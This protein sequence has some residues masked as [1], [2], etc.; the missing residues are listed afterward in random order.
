MAALVLIID[1]HTEDR[2]IADVIEHGHRVLAR[3]DTA[4]EFI[5]ATD[6][7]GADT[8]L[9]S[10]AHETLTRALIEEADGRG[11]RLLVLAANSYERRHAAELGLYDVLDAG[12]RWEEIEE[13]LSVLT[14]PAMFTASQP[15]SAVPGVIAVWGSAGA[16]GRTALA[17]T[18]AAEL[19][20]A[21][22]RVVLVDADSYGGTVAPML[23]MLDEAPGFAAACRLAAADAL[24]L[25]ELDRVCQH[26][27][28]PGGEF[29][30]LTG[31]A[32]AARWPELGGTRV[33]AV[34]RA[35]RSWVDTVVI[36][37]GSSLENDEEISSDLFAPRRNAA[38]LAAL[39]AADRVVAVAAADPIGLPRFLRA[40]GDLLE[41]VG[42]TPVDV[43]VNRVRASA[44]GMDPVG[45]VRTTLRR[46]GGIEPVCLVPEDQRGFDAA[47]L[48]GR[49]LREEAAKSPAR[50]ALV[51]YV[52]E[53]LLPPSVPLSRRSRRRGATRPARESVSVG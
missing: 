47:V 4:R 51:R 8:A 49:T 20:A 10:A 38:T 21:G 50:A 15:S 46:F 23:G 32:R 29:R 33:S 22:R 31:I 48:A 44:V 6:A 16:P 24:T 39:E 13:A 17:I 18:I 36:D 12:V 35:C 52:A 3:Y 27:L 1:R 40:Y 7:A 26:H 2:L 37:T 14:A 11:I 53:A 34:L 42:A 45:Q 25:D 19:A 30:V 43:I 9:V 41:V 5:G 28:S